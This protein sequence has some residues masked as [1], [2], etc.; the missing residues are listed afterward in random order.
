MMETPAFLVDQLAA[1]RS[2]STTMARR[3]L[4]LKGLADTGCSLREAR[5]KLGLAKT[6]VQSL[7]RKFLIDLTDYRPYAKKREKGETVAPASRNIHQP[8]TSL[9]IFGG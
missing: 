5:D 6:G 7:C 3:A 9:P 1:E 4:Y 8:A 2:V